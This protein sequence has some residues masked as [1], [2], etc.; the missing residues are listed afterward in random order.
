MYGRPIDPANPIDRQM[1]AGLPAH[2]RQLRHGEMLFG[3]FIAVRNSSTR[4]LRSA[5]RI[6]LRHD[7]GDL[8]RSLPLPASN[9]YAYAARVV[10][11]GATVPGQDGPVADD[12]AAGGRLVLCRIR[13]REYND[14][15]T[16]ELVI[17]DPLHPD[18]TASL[19]V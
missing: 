14:G 15:G 5:D 4:P 13:A 6:E 19:V 7:A 18:R 17:H 3:A 12:L 1:I 9:S 2:D 11:P 8:D 16:F 10:G